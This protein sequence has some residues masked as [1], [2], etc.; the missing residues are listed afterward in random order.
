MQVFTMGKKVSANFLPSL[1]TE[2]FDFP[3]FVSELENYNAFVTL[4]LML[5]VV[6]VEFCP[7]SWSRDQPHHQSDMT[8]NT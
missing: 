4:T 1:T 6:T 3:Q 7:V 5:P 2:Y 8:M